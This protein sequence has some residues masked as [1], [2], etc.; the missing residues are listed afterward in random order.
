MMRLVTSLTLS[1]VALAARCEI[2]IFTDFEG[3]SARVESIDQQ[4]RT[5]RFSPA[6]DAKRGW[7]C[8]WFLRADGMPE[9]GTIA[10]DLSPSKELIAQEGSNQGKPLAADWAMPER[11]TFSTDGIA[12]QHTEPGRKQDG[13]IVYEV[14]AGAPT[15]WLAWGPPFTPKDAATLAERLSKSRPFVEKFELC[16]SREGRPVP[17]L[18]VVEGPKRPNERFGVWVSARQHAWE[19]GGSWVC[20]GFADWV[21]SYDARA[22][23]LRQNA[24]IF[25]VPVMDVDHVATGDGGK[26]ALPLDHNRDWQDTPHWPEVAA[27][28][29]HLLALKEQGRCDVFLDLHNPA[30][31]DQRPFFFV[32]PDDLIA[33]EGRRNLA[34]FLELARLEITGPLPLAEKPKSSGPGYHPLWRQISGNWVAAH[35]NPHTLA[36]CLETSW[37]TPASTAEGYLAVGAQLGRAVE[38]YLRENPRRVAE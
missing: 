24:E 17:A 4:T 28:Q 33:S 16:K 6:G 35:G 19:S 22:A 2:R 23:W 36:A 31:G 3:G 30:P 9:G 5:I 25:I 1:F 29:K 38:A 14:K 21:T 32:S 34:R 10:F 20:R 13:R 27:A 7:P 37:N 11:A 15:L 8:W 12:W 18:R 26:E